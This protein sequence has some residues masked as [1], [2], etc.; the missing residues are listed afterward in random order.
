M[1]HMER[2]KHSIIDIR[3]RRNNTAAIIVIIFRLK[4][5]TERNDITGKRRG[6]DM[7]N[8]LNIY[9]QTKQMLQ[10]GD[11]HCDY[12]NKEYQMI[13]QKHVF[14]MLFSGFSFSTFNI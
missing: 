6:K 13:R 9:A 8:R 1:E 11:R 3:K 10:Y 12:N 7:I 14:V 4:G 2:A 5:E